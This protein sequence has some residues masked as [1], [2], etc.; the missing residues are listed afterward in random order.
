MLAKYCRKDR[1]IS[2]TLITLAL[3]AIGTLLSPVGSGTVRPA[4]VIGPIGEVVAPATPAP[5]PAPRD[6]IGPIGE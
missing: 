3:F 2:M 1:V 4:D 5:A 6:V